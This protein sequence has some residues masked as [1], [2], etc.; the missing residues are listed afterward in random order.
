MPHDP[1][2]IRLYEQRLRTRG[3]RI[4]RVNEPSL[5]TT[6]LSCLAIAVG[7]V[8]FFWAYDTMAHRDTPFVPSL[9]HASVSE[10]RPLITA[11]APVPNMTAPEIVRAN[12]DVPP[13][14]RDTPSSTDHNTAARDTKHS[15]AENSHAALRPKKTARAVRRISP[16]GQQA[17]ASAPMFS[18]SAPFRGW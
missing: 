2:I 11:E 15:R 16:E 13:S 5:G 12:A 1:R 6:L 8:V 14:Q 18:P 17:Y 9:A 10:H 4:W 7:T 3:A